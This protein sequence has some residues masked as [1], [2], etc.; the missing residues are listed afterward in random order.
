M[1]ERGREE[2]ELVYRPLPTSWIPSP[3]AWPL[4]VIVRATGGEG[5]V[6]KKI[7]IGHHWAPREW[8]WK[9]A[10]VLLLLAFFPFWN[11]MIHPKASVPH[12][13]YAAPPCGGL[14]PFLQTRS[15][16]PCSEGCPC[17]LLTVCCHL[18]RK[19][20]GTARWCLE[21]LMLSRW[22]PYSLSTPVSLSPAEK[23]HS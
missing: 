8:A 1:R 16:R 9:E 20:T 17:S 22:A 5:W 19:S 21:K 13:P 15:G 23:K 6:R 3:G 10:E 7:L 18:L 11:W 14:W 12:R 2:G 4:D